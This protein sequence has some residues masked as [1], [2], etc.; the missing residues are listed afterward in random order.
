ME[1]GIDRVGHD[2][3]DFDVAEGGP[4]SCQLACHQE[5]R[6]KAWTYVKPGQKGPG[7]PFFNGGGLERVGKEAWEG[8]RNGHCWLKTA[9][10]DVQGRSEGNL[11][12]G[13]MICSLREWVTLQGRA[14]H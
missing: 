5:P 3:K 7:S 11:G 13:L 1:E 14:Y 6:C 2:F 4:S 10:P 9:A 8:Q 12:V